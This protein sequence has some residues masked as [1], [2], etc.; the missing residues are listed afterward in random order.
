MIG[1]V[2]SVGRFIAIVLVVSVSACAE[3]SNPQA[4]LAQPIWTVTR[5]SAVTPSAFD[6][7]V[8]AVCAPPPGWKIQPLLSTSDHAD[9]VWLSPT[10]ATAYGVIHFVMPFPVGVDFALGAFLDHMRK[11]KGEATLLARRN[12]PSLPGI[13]FIAEDQTHVIHVNLLVAGWEGWAVYAGTS[14]NAPINQEEL[15]IAGSARENTRVG[16][17]ESV[18][19]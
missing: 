18:D 16:R 7:S 15:D 10:G 14:R 13:R 19:N 3:Q 8:N 5:P 17:P 9:Q 12:D 1:V 4:R 6:A 2:R 11:D